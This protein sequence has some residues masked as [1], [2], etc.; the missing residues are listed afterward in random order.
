LC[1]L[2]V[3]VAKKQRYSKYLQ[4]PYQPEPVNI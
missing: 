4:I 1:S 3:P 2:L